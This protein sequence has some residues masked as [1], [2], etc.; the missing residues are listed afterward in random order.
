MPQTPLDQLT[1]VLYASIQTQD[2]DV[3]DLY[4]LQAIVAGLIETVF[5]SKTEQTS[6][7]SIPIALPRFMAVAKENEECDEEFEAK[8]SDE[9]GLIP[10]GKRGGMGYI[11]RR[12]VKRGDKRYGPYLYLH[13]YK[14]MRDGKSIYGTRYLGKED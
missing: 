10:R 13:F 11:E 4:E 3:E 9:N 6:R 2:L 5:P 12:I 7:P 14:G 1:Q 8:Q